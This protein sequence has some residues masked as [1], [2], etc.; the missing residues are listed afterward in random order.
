[1]IRPG[2]RRR[3]TGSVSGFI[4]LFLSGKW[5]GIPSNQTLLTLTHCGVCQPCRDHLAS[6]SSVHECS[7][8]YWY[9]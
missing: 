4:Q 3:H 1:M 2:I 9:Y 7:L 6:L 5:L 8:S